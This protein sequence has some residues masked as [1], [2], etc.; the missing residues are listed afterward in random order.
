MPGIDRHRLPRRHSRKSLAPRAERGGNVMARP[1]R[2]TKAKR[3][4]ATTKV[5]KSL[6]QAVTV[7]STAR[8]PAIARV[9]KAATKPAK[10]VPAATRK[11]VVPPTIATPKLSK[12]ELRAQVAK[13]ESTVATLRAKSRELTRSAKVANARVSE[14]EAG[15]TQTQVVSVGRT[16]GNSAK[17]TKGARASVASRLRAVDPGN[18]VP[19]GVAVAEPQPLDDE[20]RPAKGAPLN[21][22]SGE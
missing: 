13:L 1:T 16:T 22:L 14:L 12:D 21:N 9:A 20:A 7:T 2:T 17:A 19:P 5:P 6:T 3:P 10:P 18:T 4:T 11:T 15:A 8:Q